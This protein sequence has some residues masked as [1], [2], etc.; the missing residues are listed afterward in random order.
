MMSKYK[1]T[2]ETLEKNLPYAKGIER[3]LL[4]ADTALKSNE[5]ANRTLKKMRWDDFMH[6]VFLFIGGLMSFFFTN[7]LGA[8]THKETTSEIN[9][10]QT[11]I[12]VLKSD[13]Q[14]RLNEQN[15]IILGLKNQLSTQ[16]QPSEK[17]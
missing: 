12:S 11:E 14:M 4:D 8:D 1:L 2:K 7:I 17:Q 10:L 5:I 15:S 16:S 3:D 9:K 13:F 6:I